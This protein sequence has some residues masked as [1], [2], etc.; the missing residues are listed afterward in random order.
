MFCKKKGLAPHASARCC[1][2]T[3][4]SGLKGSELG[5]VGPLR[6]VQ[7]LGWLAPCCFC[8]TLHLAIFK[9]VT[10]KQETGSDSGV[11]QLFFEKFQISNLQSVGGMKKASF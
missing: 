10:H 3:P 8:K 6:I 1:R 7:V 9:K 4:I 2:L 5:L 11:A